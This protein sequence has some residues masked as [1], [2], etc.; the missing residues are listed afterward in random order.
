MPTFDDIRSSAEYI[1]NHAD[2]VR[3]RTEK[4]DSC[5]AALKTAPLCTHWSDTPDGLP[6]GL[7]LEEKL[8]FAFVFIMT[9]FCYWPAPKWRKK[10]E[11]ACLSGARSLLTCYNE[12]YRN[13][14]NLADWHVISAFSL[15]DYKK[16]IKGDTACELCFTAERLIF[17]KQALDILQKKY[18]GSV[19]TFLQAH[20]LDGEKIC[21]ALATEFPGLNDVHIFKGRPV[22]LMK[23]AILAV[24]DLNRIY[25]NATKHPFKNMDKICA[26]A[27]Y[28][29][30]QILHRCGILTYTP[31][32]EQAIR[33]HKELPPAG[34]CELEIRGCAIAAVEKIKAAYNKLNPQSPKTTA[35][36]DNVLWILSQSNQGKEDT[37]HNTLTWFY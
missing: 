15:D 2:Y 18:S 3:I 20:D 31:A 11:N 23:R 34:V 7:T 24:S 28:K 1:A 21:R 14:I 4:I 12:A 36:I 33:A 25:E 32:L 26:S 35:N 27:G 19:L 37:H 8:M 17:L 13:G 22:I 5:L 9:N 6:T 30:P 16:I 29:L 10:R